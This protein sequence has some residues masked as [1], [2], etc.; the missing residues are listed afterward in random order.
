VRLQAAEP[1]LA[2]FE[3]SW[4]P[5]GRFLAYG[6][7]NSG[8]PS[9][10][11]EIWVLDTQTGEGHRIVGGDSFNI[12]PS[13]SDDGRSV[14]FVSNRGGGMDLWWQRLSEEAKPVGSPEPI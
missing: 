7:P 14:F 9:V 3:L 8:R 5:D 6:T 2:G 13:W 10:L 11:S 1:D 12:S 4:S